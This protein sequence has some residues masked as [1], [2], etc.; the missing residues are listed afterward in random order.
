MNTLQSKKRGSAIPLALLVVVILL[1]IGTGLLRLGLDSRI[2]SIRTASDIAARCAADA[3]LTKAL[4]EMNGKLQVKTW[5]GST[6][7]LGTEVSLPNCDAIF[8]YTVTSGADG[9]TIQSTGN[10]DQAQRT[11]SCTLQ[12]QGPFE[13]AIFTDGFINLANSA[14]VDWYN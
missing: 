4:F 3:G 5:D 6:L 11:V 14:V 12:L 9:H 1:A 2:I 10:S 7:P 8:S 13:A